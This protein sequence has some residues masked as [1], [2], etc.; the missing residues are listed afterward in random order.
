MLPEIP[1]EQF[2][3][4]LDVVAREIIL[5]AGLQQPP[6][7]A[8]HVAEQL[9]LIVARDQPAA[10]GL[11]SPRARL[12]RLSASAGPSHS[13]EGTILLAD[14]PRRERRQWAVAHEI[15]ESRAYRVFA[16]LGVDPQEAPV[17]ARED[18]ANRLASS[19]LLP[20]DWFLRDGVRV[21]WD[22]FD[23]KT[24]YATASHE[25]IARR[26]LEMPAAVILTLADQGRT[27][28]RRSNRSFRPPPLT[29]AERDAWTAAHD[30]GQPVQ[31]D[32]RELP[33]G[34][35]D[36]RAWPIHEPGWRREIIRT[37]LTLW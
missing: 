20:R 15:G 21:D 17:A 30:E 25:L 13:S 16:E 31:C 29:P 22:L 28:W 35:D 26:M 9:G 3:R 23:L 19:L 18:V 8:F 32:P 37:E 5:E 27:V 11:A 6:V 4:V 7:D 1:A 24:I 36:V 14:D 34:V 2:R 10:R 33:D 12:V